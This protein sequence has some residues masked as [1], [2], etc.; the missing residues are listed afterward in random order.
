MIGFQPTSLHHKGWN[1]LLPKNSHI[2][3][4]QQKGVI[5]YRVGLMV[6]FLGRCFPVTGLLGITMMMMMDSTSPMGMRR[7]GMGMATCIVPGKSRM[8]IGQKVQRYGKIPTNH[9]KKR[10][11][12]N[13]CQPHTGNGGDPHPGHSVLG[14]WIH[15]RQFGGS[16]VQLDLIGNRGCK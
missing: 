6:M 5:A 1:D 3:R 4:M 9:Q 12:Q 7:G 2:Q 14:G 15:E 13:P 10:K 11:Q 8:L 16:R